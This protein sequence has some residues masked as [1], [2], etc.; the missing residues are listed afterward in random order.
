MKIISEFKEFAVKGN[1][2]DLAIGVAIGASFQKIVTSLVNDVIMPPV[3]ALMG[4]VKFADLF[5]NLSD[6]P[7]ASMAEAKELGIPTLNYGIFINNILEF[8][9]VA[10]ALFI[11]VKV[12]NRIRREQERKD[13]AKLAAKK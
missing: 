5:I 4:K 11:V 12:M 1:V 3:G 10:W 8:L 9:I 6:T 7:V 13:A 2:A